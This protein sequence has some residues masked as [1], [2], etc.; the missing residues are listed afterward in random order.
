MYDQRNIERSRVSTLTI[1]AALSDWP[2]RLRP[3]GLIANATGKTTVVPLPRAGISNDTDISK[4]VL[5]RE[6]RVARPGV[7]VFRPSVSVG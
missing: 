2:G 7:V 5:Q 4:A 3:V 6:V 1:L